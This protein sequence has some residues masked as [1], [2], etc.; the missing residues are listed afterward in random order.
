M[1]QTDERR[2][3][4]Q[5]DESL[6]T[7]FTSR[8]EQVF[9]GLACPNLIAFHF[10]HD[11]N[12][13]RT[14]QRPVPFFVGVSPP[15]N[16]YDERISPLI[17]AWKTE[18]EFGPAAI[19]VKKFF[20]QGIGIEDHPSHLLDILEDPTAGTEEKAEARDSIESWKQRG[21]FVLWW[22]DDLW[23]DQSGQVISS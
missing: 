16:I 5:P 11:G 10:D 19:A 22:G 23:L 17:Q 21:D 9:M 4:I 6:S 7:G 3:T 2:Y 20:S 12:L 1:E 8:S 15:Y 14:E 13:L 18:L